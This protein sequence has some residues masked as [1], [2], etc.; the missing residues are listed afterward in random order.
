MA[1]HFASAFYRKNN[2]QIFYDVIINIVQR[3]STSYSLFL[4]PFVTRLYPFLIPL[5]PVCF[6][7]SQQDSDKTVDL[8]INFN[9]K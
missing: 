3:D 5:I 6:T 9:I 2:R 7:L 1:K 4:S 8:D